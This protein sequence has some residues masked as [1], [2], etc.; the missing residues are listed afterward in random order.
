MDPEPADCDVIHAEAIDE[1]V[2]TA[3]EGLIPLC[4]LHPD[5]PALKPEVFG[6]DIS[7]I[8]EKP[9]AK[10]GA[11]LSDYFN[12]GFN[13]ASW[14][15]FCAMQPQGRRSVRVKAEEFIQQMV[16]AEIASRPQQPP[17]QVTGGQP[18]QQQQ[19]GVDL[20]N[21]GGYQHQQHQA[22]QTAQPSAGGYAPHGQST[23]GG[24]DPQGPS[25]YGSS[26]PRQY[27]DRP[28]PMGGG[29][30]PG[31]SLRKT[32]P[33]YAFRDG[34]CSNG[35]ACNF[36]HGDEE[37]QRGIAIMKQQLAAAQQ[38]G[39]GPDQSG[40]MGGP[41]RGGY[42]P[43]APPPPAASGLLV[44]PTE[45]PILQQP[46]VV[47]G[48]QLQPP[49]APSAAGTGGGF[50]MMPP[51]PVD[52]RDGGSGFESGGAAHDNGSPIEE[53]PVGAKRARGW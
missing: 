15:A 25:G 33:C 31:V 44:P 39:A 16:A 48:L 46:L 53:P 29:P 7:L 8:K 24:H 5:G 26:G 42:Y 47:G 52:G 9:W 45:M 18:Q 37:L 11:Q 41:S 17:P 50:R 3:P 12:Y 6:Y 13:E 34:R 40:G 43:S 35:D 49:S 38:S 30:P 21:P 32:K 22:Y 4:V 27:G 10:P 20:S 1:V 19:H 14:R 28:K 2:D 36:A 23:M 51:R